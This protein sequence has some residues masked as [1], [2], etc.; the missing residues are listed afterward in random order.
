MLDRSGPGLQR[1]IDR[2]IGFESTCGHPLL[3]HVSIS[4]SSVASSV[5]DQD[6]WSC[7]LLRPVC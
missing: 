1:G 3:L 4:R 2:T 5:A 6:A 7:D